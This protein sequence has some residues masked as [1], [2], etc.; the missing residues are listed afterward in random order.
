MKKDKVPRPDRLTQLVGQAVD[1]IVTPALVVDLD[2]MDRNLTRM[3]DFAKKHDVR[4]RPHAKMHKSSG[5]ARLQMQAGAV[6]VCAQTLTEAEALALGGVTDIFITNQIIS[7]AKLLRVVA[8]S[9]ALALQNGKLAIAVDSAQ[10]VTRLAQAQV[11]SGGLHSVIDVFVEID[12]GHQR[13]G[14]EPGEAALALARQISQFDGLHFAGLHAYNGRTQHTRSAQARRD[15]VA[16]AVQ[17]VVYTRKLIEQAGFAVDLITGGG[18]GSFML[19]AASGVY[20]ELQPG[21]YLFMDADYNKN[22]RDPAQPHFEQALF[23]KTQVISAQLRH[24]V[25]DAGHKSHAVESGLPL[26][27]NLAA[28]HL[29][30]NIEAPTLEYYQSADEHGLLRAAGE[31]TRLP[32]LGQMLWLVPGHCDPT[33]AL[34]DFMVGVR[35]G[36]LHGEVERIIRVDARGAVA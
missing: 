13:C 21:S 8:V 3:A 14:V 28:A 5:L 7:P 36:L 15:A 23:V 19:E 12:V 27:H 6:G 26:V 24:V 17:D 35:G 9:Q 20:R 22:E 11:E 2:A 4:L 10:G 1:R 30:L 33:V 34:H 29:D 31:S 25:C 32:A 16:V 18:T